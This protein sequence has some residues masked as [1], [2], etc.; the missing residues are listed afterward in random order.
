[1]AHRPAPRKRE[2]GV[3]GLKNTGWGSDKCGVGDLKNT[4]W[5]V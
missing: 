1:M 3:V 4:G 2:Y 5:L